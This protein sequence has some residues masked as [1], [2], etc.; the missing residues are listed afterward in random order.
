MRGST[1]R[2]L[3]LTSQVFFFALFVFLL[4]S[5]GVPRR[6]SFRR[7][8]R[9]HS[10]AG[11]LVP[12][13]RPARRPRDRPLDG[14]ALS[15]TCSGRSPSCSSR[16]SSAGRSAAGCARSDRSTTSSAASRSDTK[17]GAALIESNRYKR[18]QATKYYVLAAVLVMALFGSATGLMLDPLS[19]LVR[20][21]SVAVLPT[22]NAALRA[23]LDTAYAWPLGPA[24]VVVN[25]AGAV[26]GATVLSF[27]QPHFNQAFLIGGLFV[28]VLV[29]NTR[30]TRFWCRAICPLGAL[31][32]VCSRWSLVQ[33][34]KHDE[35]CDDCRRCLLH[36][37]GGDDPV[38]GATWRKAE[39]HLCMNCVSDCP[40][41][42]IS[43]AWSTHAVSRD[44]DARDARTET[45]RPHHRAWPAGAVMVPLLRSGP[46]LKTS[47]GTSLIRPPGSVDE[48]PL[49][50]PLHPLRRLHEGLPEQRP[51]PGPVRRRRR[52]PV[53]AGARPAHR[54]LR[55]ELRAVL[56]GVPDRR[57]LGDHGGGEDRARSGPGARGSE[58]RTE[59]PATDAIPRPP[60]IRIGTAFYDRGRCL[61]WGMATE[62]IVCEEWCPTS[63]K[64]IYLVPTDVIDSQGQTKTVQT[65]VCRSE[66]LHGMRRVRVRVPHQGQPG[67]LRH[68]RRRNPLAREPV[69][70]AGQPAPAEVIMKKRQPYQPMPTSTDVTRREF[71]KLGA[72]SAVAGGIVLGVPGVPD[73]QQ[74]APAT[75]PPPPETNIADFMKVPKGTHA[76]PGP[77]PGKV[78]EVKDTRSFVDEKFDGK[79]ID[80]MFERG[81]RTLTG[82]DMKSSFALV[83]RAGRR[84]RHQGESRRPAAHQHAPGTRRR[85]DQVA[86]RQQGPEEQHRDLGPLRLHAEGRRAS[87]PSVSRA[88]PSKACRRWTRRGIRG[89]TPTATTSA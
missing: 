33:L 31:L 24:Q 8:R 79:V 22:I 5:D 83:L 80:E 30:V 12:R 64:A 36:C 55:T 62:C 6:D 23:G 19:F 59:P 76:L 37:Q 82:K 58:T 35:K 61:P 41:G 52:R 85:R 29:L 68:Q 1:L 71:V 84:R 49:P 47:A 20:S 17:R 73:A 53:D 66:A 28:F 56:A 42:G 50:R 60:P 2:R 88:S 70:A 46:G 54:L 45:P 48:S 4:D 89:R 39:C 7:A 27:K 14:H 13:N 10:V 9:P 16:S 34:R 63:P 69:P 86:G 3:R 78:V 74:T 81:I 44:A 32:G 75:P 77:F 57:D 87:R 18:W 43:F 51:A 67:H 26:L 40:T 65:T 15:A 72:A 25:G 21:M 38:P 11:G